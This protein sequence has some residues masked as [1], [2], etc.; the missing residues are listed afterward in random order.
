MKKK[1]P[2]VF[3]KIHK[4]VLL[5][6]YHEHTL[7]YMRGRKTQCATRKKREE[8]NK[9]HMLCSFMIFLW[10]PGTIS[11]AF[12][13]AFWD[14]LTSAFDSLLHCCDVILDRDSRIVIDDQFNVQHAHE[15]DGIKSFDIFFKWQIF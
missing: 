4:K 13:N 15:G 10:I 1:T 12:I 8:H 6:L 3:L 14:F 9:L 5:L 7:K 2:F 11:R